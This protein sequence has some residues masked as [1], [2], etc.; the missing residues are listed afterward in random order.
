[1]S[2]ERALEKGL[3]RLA[4]SSRDLRAQG[5]WRGANRLGVEPKRS[6]VT[7]PRE[8]P[9]GTEAT[10]VEVLAEGSVALATGRLAAR[11]AASLWRRGFPIRDHRRRRSAGFVAEVARDALDQ[12][13]DRGECPRHGAA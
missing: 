11:A 10:V 7:N 4:R 1:M 12:P 13:D 6:S 5:P 9:S 2:R 8:A 3:P